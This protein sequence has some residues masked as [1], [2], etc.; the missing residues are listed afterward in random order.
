M[1]RRRFRAARY[2]R[3]WLISGLRIPAGQQEF[4]LPLQQF[5]GLE[6]DGPALDVIRQTQMW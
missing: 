4:R 3:R 2:E 5:H 6:I 1:D